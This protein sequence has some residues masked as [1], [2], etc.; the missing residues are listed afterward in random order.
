MAFLLCYKLAISNT[1][2]LRKEYLSLKKEERSLEDIPQQFALLSKKEV[3]L[4]SVLQKLNLNNTAMENN[5]LRVINN[6]ATKNNIKVIDFN[7]PHISDKDNSHVMTYIFTLEGSYASILKV[8]YNL[9][10]KRNLGSIAHLGLEKKK[11]YRTKRTYLR[12]MVFLK[13]I[14]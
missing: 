13:Q 7:A 4:D 8:V 2:A 14:N 3:Y 1:L 5:V 11:E 10:T 9:E 6:E 12:A